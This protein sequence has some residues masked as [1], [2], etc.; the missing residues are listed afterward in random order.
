VNNYELDNLMKSIELC[1]LENYCAMTFRELYEKFL[2]MDY[3][4]LLY[5]ARALQNDGRLITDGDL[6]RLVV[7]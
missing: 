2:P 7:R 1:F 5:A 6:I 4:T 3:D